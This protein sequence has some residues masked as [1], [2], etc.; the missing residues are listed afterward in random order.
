MLLITLAVA[1]A[2]AS[3]QDPPAATTTPAPQ[4]AA[5]AADRDE[6]MAWW[7]K[8]RFGMFVH[9]G[10]YSPAGG[11]WQGKQYPQHYA[12]WI[13]NWAAVPCTEYAA[14][15]KPKFT[16]EPGFATAWAE[17]AK[18]AGMRYAVMT[19][20]HHEGFTLFNSKEAYSRDNP[21]TGGTN[22]SPPGRDLAREFAEA[23]RAQGI[24]PGFY[25]SLLDWQHPDAYAMA[26]PGYPKSDRVR[27]HATYKAYV[28]AH[29]DELLT[30]YG[31]LATI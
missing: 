11:S 26:L 18:A 6:R 20:K 23:M 21:I 4:L 16:P 8:A 22:I 30:G 19:A 7:R 29:V 31:D 12:E 1:A 15:M 5:W 10:L 17:L 2:V 24:K 13:Q 28:R 3:P 27:D 14:A 25:Y 9:W